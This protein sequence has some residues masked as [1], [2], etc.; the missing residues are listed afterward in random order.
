MMW[1]CVKSE[2]DIFAKKPVQ[3]SVLSS[4]IVRYKPIA[5]VD[6][7]VFEF[8]FSGDNDT[9]IDLNVHFMV[10]GKIV[11]LDGTDFDGTEHTTSVNN[12][13][14][15]LFSQC[16]ITLNGVSIT[17]TKDLYPYRASLETLL[18]YGNDAASSHLTMGFW[19]LDTGDQKGG[20]PAT[21][22]NT[23]FVKRWNLNKQSKTIELYGKIH[24]DLFNVSQFLLPGV[25]LQIRLTRSPSSF[26]LLSA[27]SD[28]KAVFKISD[29]SLFVRHV[30]PSPPIYLAHNAALEK[31][32][33]RYDVT[34][35]D[36]KTFT[37][38]AG[39]QSISIDNAVLGQL[40]KRLLFC[41]VKNSDFS[42]SAD[43]NPFNFQ[44][45]HLNNFVMYVNGRQI[46]SEGLSLDTTHEK[47]TTLAYQTLFTG[48]GI[49]HGNH[50][51]QITHDLFT[52]GLFMLLFDLTP[53]SAASEMHTSL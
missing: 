35:V 30:K 51:L 39:A 31:V 53:D 40:P 41:M 12:L 33:A 1:G 46:P 34:R 14:H 13:L 37:F 25:Q 20:D 21:S 43:T 11:K 9:Y 26:Y 38:S 44:H 3:T 15:S 29:A 28:A 5:P 19:Y 52:K 18:T 50:G 22:T 10:T 47:T 7:N 36:L 6:Q 8:V 2:F 17:P 24:A 16:S 45:F 48:S 42:G 23:G 4:Q 32:N 49:H 27:K